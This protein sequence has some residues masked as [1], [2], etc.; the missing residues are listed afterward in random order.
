MNTPQQLF[1]ISNYKAIEN[2]IING[3]NKEGHLTDKSESTRKL[4]HQQ[5]DGLDNKLILEYIDYIKKQEMSFYT[6]EGLRHLKI[7]IQ[8]IEYKIKLSTPPPPEQVPPP[9]EALPL[10]FTR[11]FTPEELKQVYTGLTKGGYLPKTTN[12]KAFEYIFE[13]KG[14]PESFTPLEWQPDSI[15]LLAYMI[16]TLFSDT[17]NSK[18]WKITEYCFRIKGK[19]PNINTLKKAIS[20]IAQGN[21]EKPK[22][23]KAIDLI[24]SF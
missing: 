24:T 16:D 22:G 1:F 11:S 21:K 23:F 19:K 8:S 2:E 3:A 7:Y 17:D 15:A 9:K 4:F 5:I 10:H 6:G 14:K 20:D 13:G 12:K 18:K